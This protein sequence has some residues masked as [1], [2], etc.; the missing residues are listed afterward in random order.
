VGPANDTHT[1]GPRA[2]VVDDDRAVLAAHARV[3]RRDGFV[4]E[5]APD[6]CAAFEAL[7]CRPFDVMLSDIAMPGMTGLDLLAKMRSEGIDVP[8]VLVTGAP[9]LDSATRA[10]EHGVLRYL[11]KPVTPTTLTRVLGE[12][13]RLHGVARAK[14]LALDNDALR[15]LID[16]LRRAKDAA[17]AGMKAKDEFLSKISHE[18]RHPMTT[19]IGMADFVA[20]GELSGEQRECVEA[21]QGAAGTLMQIIADVLDYADLHSGKLQVDPVPFTAR[22]AIEEVVAPFAAKAVAKGLSCAVS[23]ADD[24]PETVLGD[25]GRFAQILR[26]VLD[27]AVKFTD[28]GR[29]EIHLAKV[30]GAETCLEVTVADTGVGIP[31]EALA[32]V[33]ESFTQADNSRTRRFGGIGLG[34]TIASELALLLGGSL[35]V[36][37]TPDVGTKVRLRAPF[38]LPVVTD[39]FFLDDAFAL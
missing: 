19:V 2:L 22:E 31:A 34:L 24:V 39:G 6:A 10:L 21:I 4:V 27:N 18:L 11:A 14:R 28:T 13:V 35:H 9:H 3:L 32:E 29:I 12:A 23:V 25:R 7:R 8:V 36:E 20:D 5:T 38:G 37:S 17:V 15:C 33:L 30:D 26:N 1:E 16:E